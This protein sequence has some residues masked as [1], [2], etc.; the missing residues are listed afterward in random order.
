M[1]KAV[2]I[3]AIL[4]AVLLFAAC[5]RTETHQSGSP[6]AIQQRPA[7]QPS[8]AQ[9]PAPTQAPAEPE[10][11]PQAADAPGDVDP[12]L[13]SFLASYEEFIDQY[14]AFMA[15]YADSSDVIG[16]MGDYMK[17]LGQYAEF[18]TALAKYDTADMSDADALY[19]SEVCL[20]CSQKLLTVVR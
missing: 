1:K 2:P 16:M 14:V 6:S 20:R 7:A 18:E 19:Y 15:D 4:L 5:G 8:P 11:T 9:R 12:E 13:R 10:Q 17:M 3:I